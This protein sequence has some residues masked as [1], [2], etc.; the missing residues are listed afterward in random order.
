MHLLISSK[1][2]AFISLRV[3]SPSYC[4]TNEDVMKMSS[5]ETE[6][7]VEEIVRETLMM[8]SKIALQISTSDVFLMTSCDSDQ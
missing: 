6:T 5:K 3:C 2:L 1:I 7:L 4:E 8:R